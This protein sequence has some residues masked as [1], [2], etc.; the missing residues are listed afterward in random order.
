MSRQLVESFAVRLHAR[1][2]SPTTTR[3]SCKQLIEAK[4]EKGDALDTAETFGE[5]AEEGQGGEVIDL[6]EALRRSV[7][8]SRGSKGGGA[9]A[10]EASDDEDAPS[11]GTK[12]GAKGGTK[13]PA[14]KAAAKDEDKD[15]EKA[16]AAPRRTRKKASA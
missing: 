2:S 3:S 8:K 10:K 11:S 5:Q 12:R 16:E 13:K 7:E 14:A 15:D 4:L 1:A 6:M 9:S